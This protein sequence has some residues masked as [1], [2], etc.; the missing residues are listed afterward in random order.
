MSTTTASP[1]SVGF[2]LR[3]FPWL[4]AIA[5]IVYGFARLILWIAP[6][7]W[8]YILVGGL[9][10]MGIA[11]SIEMFLLGFDRRNPATLNQE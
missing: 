9:V 5:V 4:L 8:S 1:A 11:R 3:L 7:P 6:A 2:W 10:L